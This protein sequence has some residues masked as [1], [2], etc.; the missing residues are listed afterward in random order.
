MLED[1]PGDSVIKNLSSNAGDMGSIPGQ[2]TEIP[3]AMKQLCAA[4]AEP[5]CSRTHASQMERPHNAIET[6]CGQNRKKKEKYIR[7]EGSKQERMEVQ[8][9]Q[10][11][12]DKK[13][14][15]QRHWI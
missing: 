4:T 15:E 12:Q 13:S 5:V 10:E 8:L 1:F 2:G 6:Q 3:H 7:T 14:D 11:T 9:N